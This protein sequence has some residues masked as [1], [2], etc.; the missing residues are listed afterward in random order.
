MPQS[1][2]VSAVHFGHVRQLRNRSGVSL[3]LSV[4]TISTERPIHSPQSSSFFH[5]NDTSPEPPSV[6]SL[7]NFLC[8]KD[9][10]IVVNVITQRALVVI[11]DELLMSSNERDFLGDSSTASRGHCNSS[12]WMSSHF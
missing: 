11:T 10:L 9:Q 12:F 2:N 3:S 7:L 4:R 8:G 1:R 5:Y 6:P